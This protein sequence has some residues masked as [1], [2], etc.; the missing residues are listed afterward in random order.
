MHRRLAVSANPITLIARRAFW[1]PT[2]KFTLAEERL[3]CTQRV[4]GESP[5]Q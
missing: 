2:Q 5:L 4:G 1:L 3:I